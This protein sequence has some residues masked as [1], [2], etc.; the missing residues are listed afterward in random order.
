MRRAVSCVWMFLLT[1]VSLL[2]AQNA[3]IPGKFYE[4]YTV[5]STQSGTFTALGP[6]S[7]NDNG[8]CA[9]MGQTAAGQTIWVSDGDFHPPRDIN[10]SQANLGRNFFDPQLQINT[11]NQVVAKDFIPGTS[12]NIRIWDALATDSFVYLGRAGNSQPYTALNGAPSINANGVGVFGAVNGTTHELVQVTNGVPT[13]FTVN[14]SAPQP[15]IAANGSMVVTTVNRGTGL[16]QI[17]LF[18]NGFVSQTTIASGTDFSYLDTAPGISDDG[19]VVVFQGTLTAAGVT[20]LGLTGGAGPGIFASVK[21][22]S[23]WLVIRVTGLMVEVL[24][25]G[26]NNDGVCDPGETCKNAAEL[27]YDDNNNPINFASYPTNSRIAVTNLDFGAPGIAD[28]SFVISFIGTPSHASRTNPVTK[29]TPLLFSGGTGLWTIRV[30]AEHQ[31]TGTNALVF[32]PYTACLL[33]TSDAAD[34]E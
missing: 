25:S 21:T 17:I 32:H 23:A 27:G 5:A 14:A 4:Y 29:N 1:G 3:A 33:Y 13:T 30:D 19:N 26:G 12:Q 28:D 8:L 22:G 31:L 6:P 9:F 7:I 16:N 15:V 34:E 11:I 2:S 20:N 24:N 18:Q 10:P